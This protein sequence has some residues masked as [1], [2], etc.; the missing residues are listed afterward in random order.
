MWPPPPPPSIASFQSWFSPV[1]NLAR[2]QRG[3]KAQGLGAL[4]RWPPVI[5]KWMER[6]PLTVQ[7]SVRVVLNFSIRG[8]SPDTFMPAE[9]STT[10]SGAFL[11][12]CSPSASPER[13][14]LCNCTRS[15]PTSLPPCALG[16]A[17]Q[18]LTLSSHW[19]F[20]AKCCTQKSSARK[21]HSPL[22]A[23]APAEQIWCLSLMF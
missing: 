10:L 3:L 6:T 13:P 22:C 19:S 17:G 20:Q 1:F 8:A 9:E 16:P 14:A 21:K 15:P 2:P 5:L 18:E 4:P 11:V 12:H 7:A 23:L